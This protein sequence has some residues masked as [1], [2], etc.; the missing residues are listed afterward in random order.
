VIYTVLFVDF[1]EDILETTVVTFQD[2]V[3]SG[4]VK[5]PFLTNSHLCKSKWNI[6]V[7]SGLKNKN[8]SSISCFFNTISL[9]SCNKCIVQL[10][11]IL[12]Y[13]FTWKLEW[14]NAAID[15]SVSDGKENRLT[16]WL[17]HSM[18]RMSTTYCTFP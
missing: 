9:I 15:A 16:Q 13:H 14:A 7:D 8:E 2:G 5:R 6:S 10:F 4:H 18:I 3:L 11:Y 1:L 17:L 12:G